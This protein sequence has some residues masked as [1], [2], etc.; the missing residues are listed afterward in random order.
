MQEVWPHPGGGDF[1]SRISTT[2]VGPRLRDLAQQ[3]HLCRIPLKVRITFALV[4]I[5]P[6]RRVKFSVFHQQ[7]QRP[8]SCLRRVQRVAQNFGSILPAIHRDQFHGRR[9][10]RGI[11]F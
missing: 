11:G 8:R 6:V 2:L 9:D 5:H 7:L 3:I 1:Q 10:A 4:I